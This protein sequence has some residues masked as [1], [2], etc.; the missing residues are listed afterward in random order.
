MSDGSISIRDLRKGGEVSRIERK[1][2]GG[3]Y[4]AFNPTGRWIA[5]SSTKGGLS[6]WDVRSGKEVCRF[7]YPSGGSGRISWS[8][9]G[10]EIVVAGGREMA[11]RFGVR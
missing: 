4:V 11:Y 9:D 7:T 5:S 10:R 1:R 8:R 2:E 6:I 3:G